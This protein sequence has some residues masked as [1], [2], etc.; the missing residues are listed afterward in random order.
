MLNYA[1]RLAIRHLWR[2]K[3]YS[4]VMVLSLAFGFACTA[5]LLSFIV[6]E[7]RTDSFHKHTSRTFQL[8]SEDPFEEKGN[9][10]YAPVFTVKYLLDNYPE[11]ES[12]VQVATIGLKSISSS[13]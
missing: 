13:T 1:L 10:S 12:A 8:F 11:I 9:M 4:A 5:L 3:I 2:R 7:L 6:A